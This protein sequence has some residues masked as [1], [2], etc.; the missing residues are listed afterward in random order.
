MSDCMRRR[1]FIALLG[2]AVAAWPQAAYPQQG[3]RIEVFNTSTESEIDAAFAELSARPLRGANNV[4]ATGIRP[5]PA[6]SSAP[7]GRTCPSCIS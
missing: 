7:M 1:N 4:W 2:G 3:E 5:R 6:A